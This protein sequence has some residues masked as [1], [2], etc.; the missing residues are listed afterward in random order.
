MTTLARL[1]AATDPFQGPSTPLRVTAVLVEDH[2]QS[3]FLTEEPTHPYLVADW[4][5]KE[6]MFAFRLE[7]RRLGNAEYLEHLDRATDISPRRHR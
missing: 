2:Y 4:S 1:V 7:C 3:E 6:L 5:L